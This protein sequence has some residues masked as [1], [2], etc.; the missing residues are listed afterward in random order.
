VPERRDLFRRRLIAEHDGGGVARDQPDEDEHQEG[1]RQQGRQER[2]E[3]ANQ[4][5]GHGLL[6]F[7]RARAG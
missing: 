4:I 5:A 7:G 6:R 3:S 2:S 1:C